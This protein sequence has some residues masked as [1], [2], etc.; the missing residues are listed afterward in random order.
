MPAPVTR[1][2]NIERFSGGM[3]VGRWLKKLRRFHYRL[4]ND[5]RDVSPSDL[6]QSIDNLI[7]P[8]VERQTSNEFVGR[9]P[10]LRQIVDQADDFTAT[11]DDLALHI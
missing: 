11:V 5:G 4:A 2:Q 9:N 10:L 1:P 7:L 6:I 8:C 3:G